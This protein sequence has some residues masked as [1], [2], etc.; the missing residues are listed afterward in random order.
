MI[1]TKEIILLLLIVLLTISL[2]I[3]SSSTNGIV[4]FKNLSEVINKQ[5]IYQSITLLG[6]FFF[7]FVLW[8]TKKK[9]L[10]TYFQKGNIYAEIIPE[11]IVG[12][13][14]KPNENWF[15]VGINFSIIVSVVTAIVI[16]F[17]IISENGIS[18]RDIFKVLPFSI[19]LA[20]SNSFVEEGITRLGVV[21]VLKDIIKD[22]TI[23]LI[24]AGIFGVAHYWGNPGGLLGLL[25]A[26]FLGWLLSKSIIETKGIFWAWLIHFLQDVIIFSVLLTMK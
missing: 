8:M 24:S 13:K 17:Q 12:I 9:E 6:T 10:L 11:P 18:L 26:G 25:V 15:H 1:R 7:L 19:V 20:L 5:I 3:V 22:K 23:P 2:V 16:Y 4:I 21:V 14:P